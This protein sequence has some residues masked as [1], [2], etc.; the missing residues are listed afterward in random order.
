[1]RLIAQIVVAPFVTAT[2]P[3]GDPVVPDVTVTEMST[4]LSSP[5]ATED[6]DTLKV[7]E[8]E[9][10]NTDRGTVVES[11]VKLASPG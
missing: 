6:G 10:G 4:E 5:N 9:A 3:V 2:D 7:V 11:A 1:L 8:L